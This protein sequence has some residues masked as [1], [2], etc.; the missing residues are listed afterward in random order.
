[1]SVLEAVYACDL[2][3]ATMW[4]HG[5]VDKRKFK[6]KC[7]SEHGMLEAD[8][9]NHDIVNAKVQHGYVLSVAGDTSGCGWD[10]T[11]YF[12]KDEPVLT[13]GRWMGATRW[14]DSEGSTVDP[15]EPDSMEVPAEVV[16]G[17]HQATWLSL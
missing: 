10:V 4:V 1:M 5:W 6:G 17:P 11:T 12:V 16:D 3:G 15:D 9:D 7:L 13:D 2:D 8:F 14:E